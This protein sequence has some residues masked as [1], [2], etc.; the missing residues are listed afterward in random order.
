MI[1]VVAMMMVVVMVVVMIVRVMWVVVMVVLGHGTRM[2]LARG[3]FNMAL[4]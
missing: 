1:M 3:V 2:D 4:T